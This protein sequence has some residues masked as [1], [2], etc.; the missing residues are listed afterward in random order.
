MKISFKFLHLRRQI[1]YDKI[2]PKET[3]TFL[4]TTG[5]EKNCLKD[6]AK[7][8]E[9]AKELAGSGRDELVSEEL[10]EVIVLLGMLTGEKVSTEILDT[11][12][13]RFC[14]GK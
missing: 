1:I 8:L 12:F 5:R 7:H 9:K 2:L 6:A 13:S 4:I 14:I 3:E 10:K 11:I